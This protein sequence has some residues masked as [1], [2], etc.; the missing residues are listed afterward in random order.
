[1][2]DGP[3]YETQADKQCQESRGVNRVA[4]ARGC[5]ANEDG[6]KENRSGSDPRVQ[7]EL[8]EEE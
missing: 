3:D 2:H 8:L 4:A 7:E 5:N 6:A 1:V